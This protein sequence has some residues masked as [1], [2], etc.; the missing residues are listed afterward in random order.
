M[1][2]PDHISRCR[3]VQHFGFPYRSHRLT[4]LIDLKGF[5]P[6]RKGHR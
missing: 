3:D 1:R 2:Q 5:D 6:H 4:D